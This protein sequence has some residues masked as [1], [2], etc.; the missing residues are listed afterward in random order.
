MLSRH[1]SNRRRSRSRSR[2]R[3]R[4]HS[5]GI[6]R[7]RSPQHNMMSSGRSHSPSHSISSYQRLSEHCERLEARI[8]ALEQRDTEREA[9]VSGI[10]TRQWQLDGQVSQLLQTMGSIEFAQDQQRIASTVEQLPRITQ[11]LTTL[12]ESSSRQIRELGVKVSNGFS[13]IHEALSNNEVKLKE[14]DT[15]A[16]TTMNDIKH[17]GA[18]ISMLVESTHLLDTKLR[19]TEHQ[20]IKVEALVRFLTPKENPTE[21]KKSCDLALSAMAIEF[22]SKF[23]SNR[24]VILEQASS[25]IMSKFGIRLFNSDTHQLES[26]IMPR[27]QVFSVL[28]VNAMQSA[29]SSSSSSST[30]S[31]TSAHIPIRRSVPIF[32]PPPEAATAAAAGQH[33]AGC[34]QVIHL[35]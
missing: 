5:R 23:K 28:A 21:Y 12:A 26:H 19:V 20:R 27:P 8:Q 22:D 35:S 1:T 9:E 2:S 6:S 30:V 10:N 25:R 24:A 4:V 14:L 11:E 16:C 3:S 18:L 17:V 34:R 31:Y 32:P 33:A 13:I 7:S 15:A 29:M